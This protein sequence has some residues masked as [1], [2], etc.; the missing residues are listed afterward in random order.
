MN[1]ERLADAGKARNTQN[2]ELPLPP[3]Q[4]ERA[5]RLHREATIVDGTALAYTLESP[6]TERLLQAGMTAAVVTVFIGVERGQGDHT[7]QALRGLDRAVRLAMRHD[8]NLRIVL[9]VEDIAAARTEGKLGVVLAFQNASALG[10]DASLVHSFWSMGLRCIQLTYNLRNFFADGCIEK[11]PGGLSFVGRELVAAMQEV[12]ILIDLSHVADPSVHDT[13]ALAQ[14]PVAFTHCNARAL[15]CNARNKTDD[16]IRAVAAKGG[17]IGLNA[18]PAFV[19]DDDE[20]PWLSDLLDHADHL[21]SLAG[22]RAVGLGLDFIEAWGDKEKKNLRE[23]AHAFGTHYDFP[24]GLEGVAQLSNLTRGLVA[25]GHD[26]M[27]IRG[28][29]GENYVDLFRRVWGRRGG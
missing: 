19:R 1:A 12:G 25:R 27:T 4:E 13:L 21:V 6:F 23:H 11:N 29:L 9:D 8:S 16:Q 22:S 5:L 26:D 15:C 24:V 14:R 2:L 10:D 7:T 18:F 20:R 17:L 28:I 3:E